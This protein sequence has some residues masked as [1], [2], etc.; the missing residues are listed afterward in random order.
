MTTDLRLHQLGLSDGFGGVVRC[1]RDPKIGLGRWRSCRRWGSQLHIKPRKYNLRIKWDK[2]GPTETPGNV[3]R[4]HR[5]YIRHSKCQKEF[6][7]SDVI[8]VCPDDSPNFFAVSTFERAEE[9]DI[10]RLSDVGGMR[11]EANRD[12]A[13]IL[14]VSFELDRLMAP[15]PVKY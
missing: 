1:L 12:N 13:V 8:D 6:D 10:E 5:S 2:T 15:V 14:T 7:L 4:S 11:W 3:V 9:P